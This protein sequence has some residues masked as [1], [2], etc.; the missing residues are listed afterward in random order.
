MSGIHAIFSKEGKRLERYT[1]SGPKGSWMLV[2]RVQGAFSPCVNEEP[3]NPAL[4]SPIR[5]QHSLADQLSLSFTYGSRRSILIYSYLA[6]SILSKNLSYYLGGWIAGAQLGT[7]PLSLGERTLELLPHSSSLQRHP[8]GQKM[9]STE[10]A[11]LT[12]QEPSNSTRT[13]TWQT[14]QFPT[15]F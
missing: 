5:H 9:P 14:A 2:K 7:L 4:S 10:K 6:L 12:S 1:K 13:P 15:L 3:K 8:M 11:K